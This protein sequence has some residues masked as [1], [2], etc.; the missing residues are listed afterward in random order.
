MK[1]IFLFVAAVLIGLTT[2]T[3]A[4]PEIAE[5][6][7][8][9]DL[10][11][12]SLAVR[13]M[14]S[15]D[16]SRTILVRDIDV[17]MSDM[18]SRY[19]DANIVV[20][21][22]V[23]DAMS[24]ARNAGAI[25][26]YC[27]DEL[28]AAATALTWVQIFSSGAERCLDSPKLA[29]G[30]VVLTNMQK[31]SAPTIA[32]HAVALM[33]TL[34]RN[35]PQFARSMDEGRWSRGPGYTAGMSTVSGKT[36]LV[37]GLGGIGTEV[38]K[39]GEALGMRVIA[40]RNSSRDAPPF[41]SYVGLSDEMLTLAEEAHIIL[42]AL[43]LTDATRGL[44]DADFFAATQD[45]SYFINIGRG[46]TVVT[47]DLVAALQSGRLAGAGLDVTDPEPLPSD[48]TLWGLDNVIIT[49]HV[50]ARGSDRSRHM[51]LMMENIRRYIAGDALLNVVDPKKGY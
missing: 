11:E 2:S 41:V 49:P 7:Q 8:Q 17:Q 29:S 19:G 31:M 6:I 20:V 18:L 40:T 25:I 50:S 26:G 21:T 22:S 43:P 13:E 1:R 16:A 3:R 37:I 47:D 12:G 32:E 51:L 4:Q 27:D 46:A 24:R 42:N 48:H 5:L 34:T 38:A 14:P 33:L 45:N 9:S 36:L 30:E 39:R 35:L 44:I 28:L 10:K 23:E 15:W